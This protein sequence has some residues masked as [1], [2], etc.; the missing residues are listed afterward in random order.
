MA[1]DSGYRGALAELA[2]NIVAPTMV[3][4]FLSGDD[5]L[6]PMWGLI[7]ALVFPM[8]HAAFTVISVRRVSPI[9]V[10]AFISVLL[11]GGIGLFELEVHWFAWKE[12][13]FPLCLGF[14][15]VAS[16]KTRWPAIP[17]LLDPLLEVEKV[18][19]LLGEKGETGAHQASL[20]RATWQMGAILV[21]TAVVTF[22]FA[23]WMV[24]SPTG[25]EEFN[26]ELGRY[27]A[28]SFPVLGI[29]S[30]IAMAF[31]LRSVIIGIEER[32]GVDLDDLLK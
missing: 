27:T 26:S 16:V 32:T 2:V 4:M 10:L 28:A 14:A 15:A 24:V 29:P 3:L 1:N 9:A 8:G 7:C 18:Q 6:G 12:A 5:W 25:T 19:R 30:A 21:V 22:A 17:T 20:V 23:R 13:L 31:V 11:T